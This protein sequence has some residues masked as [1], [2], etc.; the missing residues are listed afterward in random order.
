MNKTNKRISAPMTWEEF[1]DVMA[2]ACNAGKLLDGVIVFSASNWKQEYTLEARSYRVCSLSKY[3]DAE[4]C[5]DS[6]FGDM[7]R[8]R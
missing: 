1:Y 3:F 2:A 4:M 7:A 6:L 5:G 8:H